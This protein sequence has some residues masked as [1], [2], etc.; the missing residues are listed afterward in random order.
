MKVVRFQTCLWEFTV[1][2]EVL[3]NCCSLWEEEE[4][5]ETSLSSVVLRN[6]VDGKEGEEREAVA[7]SLLFRL[8][9]DKPSWHAS[10]NHMIYVNIEVAF[11]RKIGIFWEG[12][13]LGVLFW[14]Q[15]EKY[16]Q[17]RNSTL[18]GSGEKQ[19]L[20]KVTLGRAWQGGQEWKLTVC[21]PLWAG[22]LQPSLWEL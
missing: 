11:R 12:L 17:D 18:K 1:I 10:W 3:G 9:P 22:G 4:A 14:Y 20:W 5:A 6:R 7:L 16:L 8:L 2:P 19:F 21:V 13:L 15:L